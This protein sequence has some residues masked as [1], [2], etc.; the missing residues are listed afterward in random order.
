ML[1]RFVSSD[2]LFSLDDFDDPLRDS[3]SVVEPEGLVTT[4]LPVNQF[5][6]GVDLISLDDPVDSITFEDD[7]DDILLA[8]AASPDRCAASEAGE[9]FPLEARDGKSC[10]TE[11]Q[12]SSSSL[13]SPESL[14]L[15]QDPASLLNGLLSPSNKKQRPSGS[16]EPPNPLDPPLYPGVLPD[17]EARERPISDRKWDLE[18][19]ELRQRVSFF[20][21][22]KTRKVPVCCDGPWEVSGDIRSCDA[23][24]MTF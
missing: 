14:Q 13:F 5:D 22:E 9:F 8:N 6:L 17:Q 4:Q 1:V 7:D 2:D 16:G 15:F 10:R 19:M 20:C 3:N 18:K 11:P 24:K 23:C 12:G 21:L